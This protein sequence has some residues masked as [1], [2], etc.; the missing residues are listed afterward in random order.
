MKKGIYR[1]RLTLLLVLLLGS[2]LVSAN[3]VK[4]LCLGD[5]LTE[6]YGVDKKDSYP[7]QLSD[8]IKKK[9]HSNVKIVNAGISGSTSASALR[10]LKWHLKSKSKPQIIILAL[11]ANDGLRGQDVENSKV[12]LEKTIQLAKTHKIEILLAG[13][14]MPPNY[15]NKYTRAFE[16]IFPELAT[17]HKL[18]LVPFLLKDVAAKK[19]LNL[20]DGIHPNEKGYTIVAATVYAHLNPLLKKFTNN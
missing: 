1:M 7:S 11:G 9:G 19:E 16:K 18:P 20:P 4:V 5:S 10:R 12:N 8:L 17:K 14:K 2:S 13:M 15:G 3:E 6:G